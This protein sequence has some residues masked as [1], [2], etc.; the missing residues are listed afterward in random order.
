[1]GFRQKMRIKKGLDVAPVVEVEVEV[2]VVAE[3]EVLEEVAPV[4]PLKKRKN[5]KS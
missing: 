1:M 2:E 3:A 4:K 5:K